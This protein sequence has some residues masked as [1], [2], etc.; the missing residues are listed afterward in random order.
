MLNSL[1]STLLVLFCLALQ[2]ASAQISIGRPLQITIQGV[3]TEEA[4]RVTG[5]YVVA[6]DG[7][8]NM[9]YIGQV[10]ASGMTNSGLATTIEAAYRNGG[11]YTTP[12]IQVVSD[13]L[14]DGLKENVVTVGGSVRQPGAVK[15]VPG[16]TLYQ[17]ITNRGGASE[18][19]AMNRVLVHSGG[20]VRV[21]NC[22]KPEG[23]SLQLKADDTIEVPEKNALG[24]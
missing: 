12:T 13:E 11:I 9:P 4:Q 14:G 18:F 15:F 22:R 2:P 6:S 23:Q 19:G 3:P 16:M 8:I 20:K 10:R 1:F 24:Q 5:S 7:T 21:V 17:A